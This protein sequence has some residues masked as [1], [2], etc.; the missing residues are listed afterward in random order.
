MQRNIISPE[1]L[2]LFCLKY[3]LQH[4]LIRFR[5][6]AFR[7]TFFEMLIPSRGRSDSIEQ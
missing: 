1:N 7:T 2:S 6:A 3:S 5:L 4:R